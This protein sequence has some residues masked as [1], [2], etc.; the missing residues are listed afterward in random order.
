MPVNP[1]A[2]IP[3]FSSFPLDELDNLVAALDVV[4]L[5]SGEILF[6]E[7]DP[8]EHMYVV[9]SGV[10]EILGALDTDDELLLNTLHEGGYLGQMSLIVP[11]SHRTASV[12]ARDDAALLSMS[13]NQF[14]KLLQHNPLLAYAA[15]NV[16]GHQ[17]S[18]SYFATYRDLTEKN[19]QL[20]QVFSEK[21]LLERE[22]QVAAEIQKSILPDILPSHDKFDFGG[23]ILPAR[24]VGGDFYDIFY[25]D[26]NRIGVLIGDVA[27]K[28]IP[29]AIFMARVHALIA[30]EAESVDSPGAVLHRVNK[31]I[32]KLEKSAQFV[33]ALYG[34]LN[35]DTSEF[36]YARAG[37]E[38][39]LFLNPPDE[40]Q[41]LPYKS[42]MAL[43]LRENIT[44]NESN[45]FLPKDSLLVMFT[46][47]MTDCR[48]SQ[49]EPFGLER[50]KKTM[51]G[52]VTL[53]AQEACDQMLED[54]MQYQNGSKQDDDVTLVAIHVK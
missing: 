5:K 50:I 31:H 39:P 47:G 19:R 1:L 30:A 52:L 32:T 23:R 12:R 11:D 9:L 36:S 53:F 25:L 48:N 14:I 46:D 44:L 3:L 10:L 45:L 22:L 15:L 20:Q 13:R 42:G 24:Q 2:S 4:K 29:S 33:T 8:S 34:V 28:G 18:D 49:G 21:E 35:T 54:L 38:P 37:H 6:H 27:D 51:S 40:I 26:N 41:R 17:L 16:V 7:G 43:G